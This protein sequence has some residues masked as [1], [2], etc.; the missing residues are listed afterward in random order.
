MGVEVSNNAVLNDELIIP[1]R[2]PEFRNNPY[3]WYDKL[4]KLAPVYKDPVADNNYI[5]TRYQ[6]ILDYG[7]HPGLTMKP[8]AWLDPGAWGL[9][10]DS[11]ITV[12]PPEHAAYRRQANKWL[13]PK[14]TA[15]W[16][17][18]SAQAVHEILDD[19]GPKGM[20]EAY[21][22][23]SLIPA[24][25]AMCTMLG[26]PSEGFDTASRWMHD[27]MLALGT[28]I[29]PEEE[30][31]CQAA[32]DYLSDRV[33]HYIEK[34]IQEPNDGMVSHWLAALADGKLNKRQLF[35]GLLL[36][37]ATAT[38]NAAYLIAGGMEVF[39]RKPE[40]FELWKNAPDQREAIFNEIARLHTAEISFTRFTSEAIEMNGVTI[41][42]GMIVRFMVASANRDPEVF[43]EPHEFIVD[44][45]DSEKKHFTFGI[46]AHSCP[47]S[48]LAKAEAFAI[49]NALAE[50]VERIELAGPPV[51]D[52]DDRNAAIDRMPLRLILK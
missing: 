51:Y 10:K 23:L 15:E 3:P 20:V 2:D 32:F 19:L 4:R 5:V 27:A 13:T 35:E 18:S 44:R 26:V 36:F 41:P 38:P 50:R 8:P 28:V 45:P 30:A 42:E 48:L 43:S 17:Q 21:R 14:K 49:Y 16:A 31:R 33:N 1:W 40:I 47:G 34:L 37:W 46:G 29:T 7:K 24:H 52:H 9:F 25:K 6:D 39:A 22:N 12:D 11:M